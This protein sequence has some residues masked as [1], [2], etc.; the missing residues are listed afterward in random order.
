MLTRDAVIRA[1]AC[2][3]GVYNWADAHYPGASAI[4]MSLAKRLAGTNTYIARAVGTGSD[5]DGYGY[6]Y[7]N[8]DGNGD[9]YGYGIGN[10][11]GYGGD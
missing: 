5:G 11:N 8:G 2:A 1:G 9:G 10:G 6:G 3:Y 4:P 7:G